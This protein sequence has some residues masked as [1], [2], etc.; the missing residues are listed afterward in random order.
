MRTGDRFAVA[1]G[2]A[3]CLFL[4]V[5]CRSLR[6]RS[7]AFVLPVARVF[8]SCLVFFLLSGSGLVRLRRGP[9]V[10]PYAFSSRAFSTARLLSASSHPSGSVGSSPFVRPSHLLGDSMAVSCHPIG[11]LPCFAPSASAFRRSS[12]LRLVL[13]P[14]GSSRF[15]SRYAPLCR[16]SPFPAPPCRSA[17]FVAHLGFVAVLPSCGSRVGLAL[18]PSFAPPCLSSGGAIIEAV[19]VCGPGSPRSLLPVAYCRVVPRSAVSFP[20]VVAVI[21]C[22]TLFAPLSSCR[23]AGRIVS[24]RRGAACLLCPWLVCVDTVLPVVVRLYSSVM[25]YI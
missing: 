6:L 17:Y 10:S 25:L 4:I 2:T 8:L 13:S 12:P 20:S 14:L 22:D 3:I 16:A 1:G 9:T 21:P 24:A 19:A 18:V 11:V 15:P 5:S 23:R 7:F